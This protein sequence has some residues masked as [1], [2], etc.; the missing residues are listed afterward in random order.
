MSYGDWVG[1]NIEN[2]SS[3]ELIIGDINIPWGKFYQGNNKDIEISPSSLNNQ[4]IPANSSYKIS[5][6]GRSGSATGT[7]GSF[8]LYVYN[9]GDVSMR[10]DKTFRIYWD[11]PFSSSNSFKVERITTN[12]QCNAPTWSPSGPL[13]DLTLVLSDVNSDSVSND[14][15]SSQDCCFGGWRLADITAC[16]LP[17][18]AA[19]GFSAV[20]DQM[21]GASYLPVLYCGEQLVNGMNYMIICKQTQ[22]TQDPVEH[23]VTVVLNASPGDDAQW[24]IV[25]IDT[26]V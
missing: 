12:L 10:G 5:A 8:N 3:K 15:E 7:E 22:V 16:N 11:V 13:G 18:P 23:L 24:S 6:C 4:R 19:S 17:Q 9:P 1:I 25:S 14:I 20:F 26:I 21:A 2:H